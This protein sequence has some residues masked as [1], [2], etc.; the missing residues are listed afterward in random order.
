MLKRDYTEVYYGLEFLEPWVARLRDDDPKQRPTA[1]E[2]LTEFQDL[3][4]KLPEEKLKARL[5]GRAEWPYG[6]RIIWVG[7][8]LWIL[9][10]GV[11]LWWNWD[12]F[13]VAIPVSAPG[14][15]FAG[16]AAVET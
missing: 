13:N 12:R 1:A 16:L 9:A 14:P 6:Y 2:A 11:L 15:R 4:A 8:S 3:I 10:N 7:I 5:L